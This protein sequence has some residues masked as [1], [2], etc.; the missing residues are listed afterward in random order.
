MFCDSYF[1]LTKK[2]VPKE[3]I[4]K[5]VHYFKTRRPHAA[6]RMSRIVRPSLRF[7]HL[8]AGHQRYFSQVMQICFQ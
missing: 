5:Y 8:V 4:K 3:L 7:L 6:Q 2:I 1:L